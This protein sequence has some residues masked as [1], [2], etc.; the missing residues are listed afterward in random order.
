MSNAINRS[1]TLECNNP[2]TKAETPEMQRGGGAASA[3]IG[4]SRGFP[5]LQYR[6]GVYY[7][8]LHDNSQRET[9]DETTDTSD[10]LHWTLQGVE[11]GGWRERGERREKREGRRREKKGTRDVYNM[12]LSRKA[13]STF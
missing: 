13:C 1:I 12:H 9:L 11:G 6:L 3:S 5:H 4:H 7:C 2:L 8:D 10:Q